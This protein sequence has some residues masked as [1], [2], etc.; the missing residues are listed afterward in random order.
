V[1]LGKVGGDGTE[2]KKIFTTGKS[3]D[4]PKI[5]EAD[6]SRAL[7]AKECWGRWTAAAAAAKL[8]DKSRL[9]L[10]VDEAPSCSD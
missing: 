9:P 5:D 7:A 6:F 2:A 10:L 1:E 4:G 3:R 8:R